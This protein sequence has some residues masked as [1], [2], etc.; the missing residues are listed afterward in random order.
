MATASSWN[1]VSE[2]GIGI[3]VSGIGNDLRGGAIEKN[4]GDG[5]QFTATAMNNVLRGADVLLNGGNGIVVEGLGNTIRDNPRVD[6]NAKNGVLVTGTGNL[7]KGNVAGS[8]KKKGNGE[9]GFAVTGAGNTLDSNKASN[10]LG[11]GFDISGGVAANPNVLKGNQSNLGN[12]G[13]P[14]E[15]KG[16]EYRLASSVKSLDGNKADGASVAKAA[17]CPGFPKKNK[18]LDFAA[19]YVCE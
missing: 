18:T 19:S 7:I 15:N 12:S 17:K 13:G 10:N 4:L 8:A 2:N 5:V 11:D 3:T 9:D 6:S 16:A 1:A 14:K